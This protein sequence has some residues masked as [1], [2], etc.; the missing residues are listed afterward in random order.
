MDQYMILDDGDHELIMMVD[1]DDKYTT[2]VAIYDVWDNL[3][4][5]EVYE[6]RVDP[7]YRVRQDF[8]AWRKE[9]PHDGE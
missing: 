9:N 6:E 8:A 1:T 7:L 2:R 5:S 4:W 3:I